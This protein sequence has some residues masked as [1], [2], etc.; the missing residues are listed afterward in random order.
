[1]ITA[2]KRDKIWIVFGLYVPVF[3][4]KT[5]IH[6]VRNTLIFRVRGGILKNTIFAKT[7]YH[8]CSTGFLIRF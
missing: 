5:K 2:V 6:R 4:L 7:F 1:M 8:R 3:K